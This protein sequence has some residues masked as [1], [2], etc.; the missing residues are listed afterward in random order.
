[1]H[2]SQHSRRTVLRETRIHRAHRANTQSILIPC[3][4]LF[5]HQTS[6][7]RRPAWR[8]TSATI[9]TWTLTHR[10]S[11]Q[12]HQEYASRIVWLAMPRLLP[13]WV[14]KAQKSITVTLT[15]L[16]T[17]KRVPKSRRWNRC[18]NLASTRSI[19][20]AKVKRAPGWNTS[21]STCQRIRRTFYETRIRPPRP[22]CRNTW[23]LPS[24]WVTMPSIVLAP[25]Q[26]NCLPHLCRREVW[27]F[28]ISQMEQIYRCCRLN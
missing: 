16:A 13:I 20:P 6:I 22:K 1:M 3:K 5:L 11:F 12:Y 21:K 9:I 26:R 2:L 15:R 27:L 25:Y 10:T 28:A 4:T 14:K 19:L 17:A 7:T 18:L 23:T 24:I 8:S